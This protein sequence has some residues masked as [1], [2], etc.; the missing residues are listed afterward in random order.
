MGRMRFSV[1]SVALSVALP[2]IGTGAALSAQSTYVPTNPVAPPT[3]SPPSMAPMPTIAPP[4]VTAPTVSA[5]ASGAKGMTGA[6][7]A[8]T[9]GAKGTTGATGTDAN[10][11][12]PSGTASASP[13]SALSLLGLNSDN[14][15]LK[16]LNGTDGDDDSQDALSSLLG[17]SSASSDSATL[18]KILGL[19][20]KEQS[21][22]SASATANTDTAVNA[23]GKA[24]IKQAASGGELVRLTVDGTNLLGGVTML[25]SSILAKDGSFLLTGDRTYSSTSGALSETFYFLCRKNADGSYRLYTDVSQPSS[26]PFSFLY[27]LARAGP[28]RGA[29]TGDL[30]VFRRSLS[31]LSADVVIRV[32]GATVD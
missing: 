30:I 32:I 25:V 15:L 5:P 20:E 6:Q 13:L 27:R 17:S 18:T 1:M 10:G 2:I 24:T 8:T 19:L 21:R 11:T 12:S 4:V 29:R 26:Y 3:V 7:S 23:T 9:T 14:A 16:A 31:D 28:I 22:A